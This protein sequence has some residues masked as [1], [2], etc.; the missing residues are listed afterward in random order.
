MP[1]TLNELADCFAYV[2]VQYHNTIV[3]KKESPLSVIKYPDRLVKSADCLEKLEDVCHKVTRLYSNREEHLKLCLVLY[4]EL[5]CFDSGI[6]DYVK[7]IIALKRAHHEEDLSSKLARFERDCQKL[8]VDMIQILTNLYRLNHENSAAIE[9][10]VSTKEC[11]KTFKLTSTGKDA[12]S[13]VR[14]LYSGY[15]L[16]DFGQALRAELLE[17]LDLSQIPT[18]KTPELIAT[19]KMN[20]ILAQIQYKVKSLVEEKWG[21]CELSKDEHPGTTRR[22]SQDEGLA[23][24]ALISRGHV[25]TLGTEE[26]GRKVEAASK[27]ESGWG[28]P[29]VFGFKW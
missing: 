3:S 8:K 2:I 10:N 6:E 25:F 7:D 1:T 13:Y 27:E 15:L 21:T 22:A 16:T 12:Y 23:L 29:S 19:E 20:C 4:Q 24:I 14:S 5:S 18:F 28:L 11:K 17:K 26:P 9:F